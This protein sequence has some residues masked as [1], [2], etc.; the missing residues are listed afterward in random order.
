M[1]LL[2][3]YPACETSRHLLQFHRL[4]VRLCTLSTLQNQFQ[5][6]KQ[7][8]DFTL[9]LRR[10]I[11]PCTDCF[12][13]FHHF[14]QGDGILTNV[15]CLVVIQIPSARS[16]IV[17]ALLNSPKHKLSSLM[18]APTPGIFP[19]SSYASV[20]EPEVSYHRSQLQT[21]GILSVMTRPSNLHRVISLM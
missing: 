19:R 3:T 21:S 11:V 5:G 16:V 9:T 2:T 20:A 6:L 12:P 17:Y 7:R 10:I 1:T 13:K 4:K 8:F 18:T 15:I 14:P